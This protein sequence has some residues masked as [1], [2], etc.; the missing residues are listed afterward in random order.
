MKGQ[1]V[2]T[3]LIAGLAALGSLIASAQD[4]QADAKI[5]FAFTINHKSMP[6]GEYR[7]QSVDNRGLFRINNNS[8]GGAAFV[9]APNTKE[10]KGDADQGHLT[11]ACY[12][13]N[14]V[15]TQ[16]WMPGSSVGNYRSDGAVDSDLQRRLGVSTL[17]SVR[18]AH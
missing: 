10:S 1:F 14:C 7:V 11:F 17:V 12:Q 2:R 6:S 18:L 3:V 16:I 5:P 9:P 4:R 13:G 15:L 8:K